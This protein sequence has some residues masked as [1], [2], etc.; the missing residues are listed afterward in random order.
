MSLPANPKTSLKV[1][2]PILVLLVKNVT[3]NNI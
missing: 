2:M 3:N 1:K